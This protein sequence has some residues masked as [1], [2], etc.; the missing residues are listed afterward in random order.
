MHTHTYT[1]THA[2]THVAYV[3]MDGTC[4]SGMRDQ[5]ESLQRSRMVYSFM[6][7]AK[8]YREADTEAATQ[9]QCA[10]I[11]KLISVRL[12]KPGEVLHEGASGTGTGAGTG[13]NAALYMV[14]QGT[15]VSTLTGGASGQAAAE[16]DVLVGG[17]AGGIAM[18]RLDGATPPAPSRTRRHRHA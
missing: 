6:K 14:Y 17:Y 3:G 2:H 1:H 7:F 12:L 18:L 13:G 9:E 10:Q 8:L 16:R 5:V 11:A 4:G 15:L